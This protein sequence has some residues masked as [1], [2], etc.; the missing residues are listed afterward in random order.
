VPRKLEGFDFS[1]RNRRGEQDW[2]TLLNGETWELRYGSDFFGPV[3]N[4]R[5][6]AHQA[7]ARRGLKVRAAQSGKNLIVQAIREDDQ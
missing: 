1:K 3:R 7:A 4:M 2:D 6:V 5:A